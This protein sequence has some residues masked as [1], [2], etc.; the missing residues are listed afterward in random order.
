M[1]ATVQCTCVH[2]SG[3][4]L[5]PLS[6]LHY[7]WL[8]SSSCAIHPV[9]ATEQCICVL[10]CDSLLYPLS[11]K[12][13]FYTVPVSFNL[14]VYS[15]PLESYCT[16]YLSP[17]IWPC[18]YSTLCQL[19]YTLHGYAYP[20]LQSTLC[21]LLYTVPVSTYPAVYSAPCQQLYTVPVFSICL[22]TPP[23]ASNCT[24]HLYPPMRLSTLP[25]AR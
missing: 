15:T 2:L 12:S 11:E 25:S 21:Q 6:T 24:L 1:K 4:V 14:A 5:H 7:T 20:A 9:P 22:F 8:R 3:L 19:L 18:M 23:S 10:Q 17:L 16:L 13:T